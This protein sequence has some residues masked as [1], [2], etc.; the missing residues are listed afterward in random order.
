VNRQTLIDYC[1]KHMARIETLQGAWTA[2][3]GWGLTS[4]GESQWNIW[5]SAEHGLVVWVGK[6]K[7]EGI[8]LAK[9]TMADLVQIVEKFKRGCVVAKLRGE[10]EQG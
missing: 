6:A 10:V 5:I 9:I 1:G 8:P 3:D 4:H 7:S 2:F